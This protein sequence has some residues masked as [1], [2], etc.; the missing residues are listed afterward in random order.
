MLL[1]ALTP[2]LPPL[3]QPSL[4]LLVPSAWLRRGVRCSSSCL[5]HPASSPSRDVARRLNALRCRPA[6]PAASTSVCVLAGAGRLRA[7]RV[8]ASPVASPDAAARFKV[9]LLGAVRRGTP[10]LGRMSPATGGVRLLVVGGP[11]TICRGAAKLGTA[12]PPSSR[13]VHN[14]GGGGLRAVW[15]GAGGL[16]SAVAAKPR[17]FPRCGLAIARRG[18]TFLRLLQQGDALLPAHRHWQRLGAGLAGGSPR[19][20]PSS[21]GRVKVL[22]G[23]ARPAWRRAALPL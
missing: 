10:R 13:E 1:Q 3:L 15:R 20:R 23:L 5:G 4:I 6:P 12:V 18:G 7:A 17:G 8:T 16:G 22:V 21:A 14:L 2:L 11:G 19:P 9:R